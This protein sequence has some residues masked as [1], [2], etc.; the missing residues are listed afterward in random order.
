MS[1]FSD[2]RFITLILCSSFLLFAL[3]ATSPWTKDTTPTPTTPRT[4]S[5]TRATSAEYNQTATATTTVQR[6][7]P[8]NGVYLLMDSNSVVR[9]VGRGDVHDRIKSQYD[10][11]SYQRWL[12]TSEVA[13]CGNF[14]VKP[15]PIR[16]LSPLTL[17]GCFLVVAVNY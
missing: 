9:Y 17:A 14:M 11:R 4:D 7:Y 13:K 12:N 3:M 8:N 16:T 1:W 2:K 15:H 5:P 6:P 10:L